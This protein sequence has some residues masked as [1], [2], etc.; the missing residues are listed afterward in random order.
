[1]LPARARTAPRA[2]GERRAPPGATRA[3]GR[4]AEADIA[5]ADMVVVV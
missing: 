4:A 1:M 3:A 5:K 2:A